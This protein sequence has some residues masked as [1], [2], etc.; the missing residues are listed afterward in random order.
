MGREVF[1]GDPKGSEPLKKLYDVGV[2]SGALGLLINSVVL[3]FISLGI[4][5]A[6]RGVGGVNK[7]WGIVNMILAAGLGLTIVVTKVA[8]RYRADALAAGAVS[9]PLPSAAIKGGAL[10]I[11]GLLGIP[12]AITF[13]I[14]FAL[15]SIF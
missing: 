2:L 3:G 12:L 9:P 5:Q 15:A 11:F 6:G 8:E 10:A 4:E 7:L 1:G 13:S 14:P